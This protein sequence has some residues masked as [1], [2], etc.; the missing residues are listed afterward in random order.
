MIPGKIVV[1][2]ICAPSATL[3][4]YTLISSLNPCLSC[5][6][7]VG[8][9]CWIHVANIIVLLLVSV[10]DPDFFI[11]KNIDLKVSFISPLHVNCQ[12]MNFKIR[13]LELKNKS[14]QAGVCKAVVQLY[15]DIICCHFF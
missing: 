4:E 3:T 13:A 11:V 14:L 8:D 15:T 1:V 7:V 6:A 12:V 10:D 9:A 5:T 2:Y